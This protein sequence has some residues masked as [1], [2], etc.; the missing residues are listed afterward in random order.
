MPNFSQVKKA[1][2]QKIFPVKKEPAN[3]VRIKLNSKAAQLGQWTRLKD[4]NEAN[5]V[6]AESDSIAWVGTPV[7]LV[8]WNVATNTYQTYDESN[9][10]VFTSINSLAIDK[11]KQLW[12]ST[13]QGIVKYSNGTF[14]SYSYENS[15][16]P[17]AVF[18]CL[19]IDSLN[20]VYVGYEAYVENNN[21][22]DGGVAVFT[23]T[24]WKYFSI[25]N[26]LGNL[27]PSAIYTYHDTVWIGEYD[28]LYT[29]ANDSAIVAPRW[30]N[31]GIYSMSVDYQDSLWT[32]S[33]SRK[34]LKYSQ[35]GWKLMI[36]SV[37]FWQAIWNDP[38]G[39]LWLSNDQDTWQFPY[40]P[41]RLN[42]NQMREGYKCSN[43]ELG[44]PGVCDIPGVPGQFCSQYAISPTSQFFASMGGINLQYQTNQ[45]GLYTFDGFSWQVFRVPTTLDDN[46]IYGLGTDQNGEVYLS[47]PYYTQKTDGQ[48]FQTVGGWNMGLQSWNNHFKIAPD[49]SIYTNHNQ[50]YSNSGFV[51]GL[52]FDSYGNLWTTYPLMEYTWPSLASTV[53]TDSIIGYIGNPGYYDPQFMDVTTDKND[54]VWAAA[55]YYG[56]AAFDRTQWHLLPPGDTTLPN[57]NYD[58]VFAD[59]KN[60]IWFCTNQSSPNYGFTIFDGTDWR[61][62]YS[63]QNY[64]VADVDQIAED[65]F[66]NDWLATGGGLLKYDGSSFTL[67]NSGN[68]P[69]PSDFIVTAVTVDY[70]SNIWIGTHTGLYIFNPYGLQLGPYTYRSPVDT[71][72]IVKSGNQAVAHFTPSAVTSG[73]AKYELQRGRGTFK[74]WTVAS[75][76]LVPGNS[77]M[78][79]EDSLPII[80]NY[81]YRIK[82]IG[83]DG[84]VSFSAAIAF[85]GGS[86]AVQLSDCKT[87]LSGSR[88]YLKWKLQ[89]ESFI[90]RFEVSRTEISTGE[91]S[92]TASIS[93]NAPKNQDGY[94]FVSIDSLTQSPN[95]YSYALT[96]IFADSSR[97]TLQSIVAV[98]QLPTAFSVTQNYPNPFNGSTSLAVYLPIQ[99]EVVFQFY[100]ILGREILPAM[101]KDFAAGYN[102]IQ[103]D[104][105]SLASGFYLCVAK[106]GGERRIQ[107]LLLVK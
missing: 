32:F 95:K 84:R 67:F 4:W 1:R 44:I 48:N 99:G 5:S 7:G 37:G 20:N 49:G 63:P 79:I 74:F 46:Y 21:F 25:H 9:G 107:K 103:F 42:I 10:L 102:T 26:S 43:D 94:Y 82:R 89:N 64:A 34:M 14:T 30:N 56:G 41:Y 65:H 104:F 58:L 87:Y 83:A 77:S 17:P 3:A 2:T 47:T 86:K 73:S 11:R 88:L 105:R 59:S 71:F 52:D 6:V 66:G 97:V 91:S 38:A 57:F 93:I 13:F 54:N 62:Y 96:A 24:S 31:G 85:S 98:P 33:K 90:Y 55:W 100:D 15:N 23:G 45:G 40:G 61:T 36:D 76:D 35:D 72:Y 29:L 28:N 53:F 8:R 106:N 68:S 81:N 16:L 70:A 39:G 22:P 12:I 51:T 18:T 69:L 78:A 60:R 80:G 27:G 75:T 50:I 19:T 92:V 101:K